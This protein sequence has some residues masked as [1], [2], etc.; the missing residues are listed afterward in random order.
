MGEGNSMGVLLRQ[1]LCTGLS[2]EEAGSGSRGYWV[3]AGSF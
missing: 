2:V 3:E 1:G